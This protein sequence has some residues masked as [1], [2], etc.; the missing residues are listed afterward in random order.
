MWEKRERLSKLRLAIA[1]Y[2]GDITSPEEEDD[3]AHQ[4]IH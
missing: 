3:I 1:R 2:Q 4:E